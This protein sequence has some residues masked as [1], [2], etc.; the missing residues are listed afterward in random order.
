MASAFAAILRAAV[1]QTPGALGSAFA[2]DD[3]ETVDAIA[4]DPS[5]NLLD[6]SF[7][8]AHYGVVLAHIQSALRTLHY[9]EAEIVTVVHPELSVLVRPVKDG[10]FAL[11][12]LAPA[13]SLALAMAALDRAAL[14]LAEEMG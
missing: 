8:A 5:H 10:Y 14:A 3:G 9:G 4:I 6:E 1:G 13:S 7:L 2:A 12:A 11:L